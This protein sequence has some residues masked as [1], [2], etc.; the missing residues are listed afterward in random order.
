MNTEHEKG[1]DIS[2]PQGF[3]IFTHQATGEK[4][5]KKSLCNHDN[6]LNFI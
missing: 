2:T 6:E 1:Q 3:M 5:K 4:K